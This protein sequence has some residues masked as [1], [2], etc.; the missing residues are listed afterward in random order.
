MSA[1]EY[2]IEG[3]PYRIVDQDGRRALKFQGDDACELSA[4]Q[5]SAPDAFVHHYAAEMMKFLA[6]NP[7]PKDILML[8]LGGGQQAKYILRRIADARVVAVE[9]DPVIV[10]I[11][12]EYFAVP[13]NHERLTV[14]VGAADDYV[15][16]HPDNCDVI[17]ADVCRHRGEELEVPAMLMQEAFYRSCH[18]A[19]RSGGIMAINLVIHSFDDAYCDR[20]RRLLEAIFASVAETR[21]LCG[22]KIMF[23]FKDPPCADYKQLAERAEQLEKHF[24]LGLP[25]Y[26][27]KLAAA[28]VC[29]P[30]C[31]TSTVAANE[32]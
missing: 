24:G 26:V 17:L 28:A 14:V 1:T 30:S 7:Q 13:A 10:R 18:R 5:L 15:R 32:I 25:A 29:P 16:T 22:Q 9:I 20:H 2:R 8:G 4:M 21:S 31:T 27:A 12:H 11:A 23:V 19:L 6:F 3:S